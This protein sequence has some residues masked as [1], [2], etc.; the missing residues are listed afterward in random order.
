MEIDQRV[1]PAIWGAMVGAAVISV[2]GFSSLGWTLG[3]T[4]EEMANQRAEA[5]LV[6]AL[7][8]ICVAKFQHQ[9]NFAAKLTEFQ[10][11]PSYNQAELIEKGGWA[12]MPGSDK[13]NAAVAS[14]CADRL[15][16]LKV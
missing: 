3:S 4:A 9:A 5:A 16:R 13:T 15:G 1:K 8:P 7:T 6:H 10:N 14:A 2:I 12:S 11:T